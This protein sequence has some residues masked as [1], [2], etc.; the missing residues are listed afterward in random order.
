MRLASMDIHVD[1]DEGSI[2]DERSRA[3][4]SKCSRTPMASHGEGIYANKV[5][6][7]LSTDVE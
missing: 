7:A 6:E 4:T 1:S 2:Q 5:L 3:M